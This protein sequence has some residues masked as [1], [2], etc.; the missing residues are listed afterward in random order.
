MISEKLSAMLPGAAFASLQTGAPGKAAALAPLDT[1]SADVVLVTPDPVVIFVAC[2]PASSTTCRPPR[3]EGTGAAGWAPPAPAT[4]SASSATAP[5]ST[6]RPTSTT[7]SASAS[8]STGTTKSAA[9]TSGS[10][11]SSGPLAFL[12]DKNLSVEEKIFRLALY[13]TD[14]ADKELEK[15]IKDI[16]GKPKSASSS[17]G[18]A[19]GLLGGI[20][21]QAAGGLGFMGPLGSALGMGL[22]LLDQSGA[23]KLIAQASGPVLA[24]G[25]CA[26][27][28]PGLAPAAAKLGPTI[29]NGA[30]DA[31]EGLSA[32]AS[33]TSSTSS[34]SATSSSSSS[35]SGDVE[36]KDLL[37]LEYLQQKQQQMFS[38]LSNLM[39][40]MH[41]TR[42][43]VIG[44]L[45]A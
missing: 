8:K 1:R 41:D 6:S 44:N 39:K 45:R 17:G 9:S 31:L 23:T 2:P 35:A 7:K 21:G 33:S 25:A 16:S 13:M 4:G 26:V 38:L 15:K 40:G 3:T 30:F 19:G 24:A 5:S 36:K 37:E 18:G 14:K 34:A 11:K 42:M 43:S 32:S 28:L 12:E 22:H 29:V 10:S 27:G 20:V